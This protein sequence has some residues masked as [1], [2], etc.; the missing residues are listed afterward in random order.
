MVEVASLSLATEVEPPGVLDAGMPL[1][2]ASVVGVVCANSGAEQRRSVKT[3]E[4]FMRDPQRW[5][6][7]LRE[8]HRWQPDETARL[9]LEFGGLKTS[10]ETRTVVRFL[11]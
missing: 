6:D 2:S 11:Q 4:F 1:L 10:Y 7:A 5:S 8:L 9:A 3:M